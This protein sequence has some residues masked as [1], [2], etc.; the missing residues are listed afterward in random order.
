MPRIPVACQ[1]IDYPCCGCND[2]VLTGIDALD[3]DPGDR[4]G[5]D[6]VDDFSYEPDDH[7]EADFDDSCSE[8]GFYP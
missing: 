6:G 2:V 4:F 3:A 5:F 8:D 7:L 1:H